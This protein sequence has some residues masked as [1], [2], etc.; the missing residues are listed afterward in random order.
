M[1][2]GGAR[3]G[4][5]VNTFMHILRWLVLALFAATL[6]QVLA[7][8]SPSSHAFVDQLEDRIRAGSTTAVLTDQ[9]DATGVRV[10]WQ[11]GFFSWTQA[12]YQPPG[13]Q[14][15]SGPAEGGEQASP[16][17]QLVGELTAVARR[18]GH[19]VSVTDVTSYRV[20]LLNAGQLTL[21]APLGTIAVA[22]WIVLF[23]RMLL[24]REHR[25]AN[26]WA[27]FWLFTVGQIGA[28]LYV[29]SEPEPLLM[30]LGRSRARVQAD[31]PITGGTGCLLSIASTFLVSVVGLVL[32]HLLA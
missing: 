32:L 6:L 10:L 17:G 24:T 7:V 15:G 2:T 29:W 27:W 3:D 23:A 13:A 18:S 16:R 25:Y 4:R 19:T 1:T 31:Q 9:A 8:A 21:G 30:P 26:R 12:W 11:T 5:I 20:L 28:L 14:S 22:L